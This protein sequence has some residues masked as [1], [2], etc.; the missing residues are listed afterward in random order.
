MGNGGRAVERN[1]NVQQLQ[2]KSGG[3][4]QFVGKFFL[5]NATRNNLYF[6]LR[7]AFKDPF[8]LLSNKVD[9]G[10]PNFRSTIN[11]AH[12]R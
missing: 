7:V 6:L 5:E 3:V 12:M 4:G 2:L 1:R 9:R 8:F 11:S 10:F